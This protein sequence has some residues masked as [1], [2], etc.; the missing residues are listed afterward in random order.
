MRSVRRQS[1]MLVTLQLRVWRNTYFTSV[2]PGAAF[3][4]AFA[5]LGFTK[6]QSMHAFPKKKLACQSLRII[7]CAAAATEQQ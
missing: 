1:V 3:S 2:V 5:C 4:P 7:L 6:H